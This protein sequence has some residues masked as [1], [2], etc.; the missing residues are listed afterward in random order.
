MLYEVI[1][2]NFP[3]EEGGEGF[4]GGGA[5]HEFLVHPVLYP[6]HALA[7]GFPAA[8]LAPYFPGN[9]NGRRNNFV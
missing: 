2:G 6:E 1:T 9:H 5:N 8:R 7:H 4:L 3:P